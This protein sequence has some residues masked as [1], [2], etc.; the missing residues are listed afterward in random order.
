MSPST[1]VFMIPKAVTLWKAQD[2]T[3]TFDQFPGD[4]DRAGSLTATLH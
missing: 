2:I 1:D 4:E 3:R